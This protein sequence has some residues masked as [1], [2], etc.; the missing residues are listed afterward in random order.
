MICSL[1]PQGHIF[2]YRSWND[3]FGKQ[4]Y[5]G[6]VSLL[7]AVNVVHRKVIDIHNCAE[8]SNDV[9][10]NSWYILIGSILFYCYKS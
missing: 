8:E 5:E 1:A 9:L 4:M 10:N 3:T 2:E 6:C 7:C